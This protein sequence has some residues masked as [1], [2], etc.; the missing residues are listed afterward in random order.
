[1]RVL[2]IVAFFKRTLSSSFGRHFN[3]DFTFSPM[4]GGSFYVKIS[5]IRCRCFGCIPIYFATVL[6]TVLN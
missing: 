6:V 4:N 3:C 1:M 5:S 2:V